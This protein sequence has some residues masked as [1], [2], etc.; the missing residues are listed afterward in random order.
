MI[1]SSKFLKITRHLN[2]IN[3]TNGINRECSLSDQADIIEEMLK[4]GCSAN[5]QRRIYLQTGSF[6]E[7]IR[8]ERDKFW[9]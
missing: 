8:K 2:L 4:R 9:T 5:R 3:R 1:L 6:R 7:I